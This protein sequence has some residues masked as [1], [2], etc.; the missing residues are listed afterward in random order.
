VIPGNN[1][2]PGFVVGTRLRVQKILGADISRTTGLDRRLREL[3][4]VLGPNLIRLFLHSVLN[5]CFV[6]LLKGNSSKAPVVGNLNHLSGK[7]GR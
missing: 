6:V 2:V 7:A 5:A 4:R 1:G 3:T